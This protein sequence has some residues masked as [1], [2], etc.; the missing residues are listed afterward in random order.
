MWGQSRKFKFTGILL[1]QILLIIY[2]LV[3]QGFEGR[4]SVPTQTLE[5]RRVRPISH[6]ECK[7]HHQTFLEMFD[8]KEEL[9]SSLKKQ[10]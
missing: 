2:S 7:E 4:W 8:C 6:S 9:I 1:P 5:C 3:S 10:C